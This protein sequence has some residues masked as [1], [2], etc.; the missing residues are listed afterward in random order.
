MR[1]PNHT[2]QIVCAVWT[3]ALGVW[4]IAALL[5][6]IVAMIL[7]SSAEAH[8]AN[9]PEWDE[10]FAAMRV[11]DDVQAVCCDKSYVYLLEDSAVR[12]VDGQY[13]AKIGDE[14]MK[15]PNTGQGHPGNTVFGYVKN[16]T[17]G[18]VAWVFRGQPR[19]FAE[20][21]GA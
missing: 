4:V 19:C 2:Q 10:W 18:Y 7:L 6:F 14:W 12:I 20:G 13:E 5:G 11:P 16:P 8:V 15:F 21:T 3:T 17:G 1:T 9:H